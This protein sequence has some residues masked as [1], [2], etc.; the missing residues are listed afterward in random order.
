MTIGYKYVARLQ[1]TSG[2]I[3]DQVV[4]NWY[5]DTVMAGSAVASAL[6]TFYQA[7]GSQMAPCMKVLAGSI[8]ID[9]YAI[10]DTRPPPGVGLGPPVA[11]FSKALTGVSATTG[12]PSE[13]AIALSFHAD[14]STIPEHGPGHT[15][16]RASY[17]GRVYLGEWSQLVIKCDASTNYDS[18]LNPS[19]ITPIASAASAL[20]HTSG[21]G[22]S[23][24]SKK[25]WVL[26]EVVG[27]WVDNSFDSAR[28]RK[29]PETTKTAWS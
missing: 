17:R 20:M 24:F 13:V 12:L 16:P 28:R 29:I 18:I 21:L 7:L 19:S 22:W 8:F 27:G 2:V 26:H 25:N 10:P 6:E 14:Y 9:Q 23:V 5:T 1:K 15:R 11:S 3:K 4:N